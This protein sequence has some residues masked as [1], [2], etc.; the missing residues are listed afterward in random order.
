MI[1]SVY[2]AQSSRHVLLICGIEV[3]HIVGNTTLANDQ[4]NKMSKLLE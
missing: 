3:A 2:L 4:C 1:F